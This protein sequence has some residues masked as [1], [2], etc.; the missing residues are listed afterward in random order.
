MIIGHYTHHLESQGG[1]EIYLKRIAT[2]QQAAGHT[3]YYFSKYISP[4]EESSTIAVQTDDVLYEQAKRLGVELLHLHAS[5]SL[6]PPNNFVTVRTMHGHQPYCP[7]GSKYLQRQNVPCDR[8]YSTTRC[9]WGH[10]VDHCGSVRPHQVLQNFQNTWNEKRVLAQ[11]PVITNSYFVKE[12]MLAA[13]YSPELMYMLYVCAA[14]ASNSPAPPDSEIPR[15]MF[16]GRLTPEKGAIWLLHALTQVKV[17]VHLDII[18]Q[19][20]QSLKVQQ[21][22]QNLNLQGQVTMHGWLDSE[23]IYQH[24]RQT[25]ALIFPSVWHEPAGIVAYE[26]MLNSRAVIASKVGGIPEGVIDGVTG[27]LVEPNDT[28]GLA[29]QIERLATDWSL[30]RQL[31]E[32]GQQFA[33][34]TYSLK[35]HMPQLMQFYQQMIRSKQ[36]QLHKVLAR[37]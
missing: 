10:L 12:Q 19:G 30:A 6:I 25:R 29:Q 5:V 15:F 20:N 8:S 9:L 33:V 17:P 11:I 18:G 22:I 36:D 13:G 27:L 34:Q 26:A 31:G 16:L 14:E 21:T 7:S 32:A 35:N 24:F 37:S 23:Q 1:A 3:V 2:A 28:V 4:S